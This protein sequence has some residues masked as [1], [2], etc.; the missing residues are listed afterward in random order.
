MHSHKEQTLSL[1]CRLGM[2]KCTGCLF[3]GSVHRGGVCHNWGSVD[4]RSG[5]DNGGC[6][7][8]RVGNSNGGSGGGERSS[9][10]VGD[11][12]DVA[13]DGVRMVVYVLDSAIRKSNRVGALSVAGTIAAL[14]GVEVGVGVVV[15]DGVVV[16]VGGD[17]VRVHLG[18]TVGDRVG[19]SVNRGMVSRGSVD[20]RGSMVDNRG[21][22][23]DKRGSVNHRGGMGD[24]GGSMGNR[25]SNDTVGKAMSNNTVGDTMSDDAMGNTVSDNTVSNSVANNTV[26]KTMSDHT[27]VTSSME[28]IGVLS[29]SSN[30]S[31]EGL[32]LRVV[33]DLSLEG[34]GDGH[35]GSLSGSNSDMCNR[36]SSMSGP[37]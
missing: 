24:N 27:S 9:A 36:V 12:S 21:S 25:V 26:G 31:S 28:G 20:N 32:G 35:M 3:A 16:S 22:V 5:V 33:S 11:L 1:K 4:N 15:S 34:L 18:N 10:V 2:N 29:N 23:V 13:V 37:M 7:D 19:N 14:S 6:V 17:L 8:N 30:V